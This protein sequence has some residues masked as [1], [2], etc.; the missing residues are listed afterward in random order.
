MSCSIGPA[1][2][3]TIALGMLAIG[4]RLERCDCRKGFALEELEEGAACSR[5]VVD[6]AGDAELVDRGD[7]VAATGDGVGLRFRDRARE[8]LGSFGERIIFEDANR[9]VPDDRA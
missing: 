2:E 7:R 6:V 8:R 3:P 4:A 1:D 5:D 9:A